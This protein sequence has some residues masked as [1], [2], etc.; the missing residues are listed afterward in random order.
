MDRL[1]FRMRASAKDEWQRIR[2]RS[3]TWGLRA[4]PLRAGSKLWQ[5]PVPVFAV[6]A[7]L[8]LYAIQMGTA[9][10]VH[11]VAVV[12]SRILLIED[13]SG[14]MDEDGIPDELKREKEILRNAL[15]PNEVQVDG[16]G[17]ISSGSDNLRT[18]LE[19]SLP[20][21]Q[22]L[23]AVYFLSDFH[24]ETKDWDCDDAAGV[25]EVRRLVRAAGVRLYLSSVGML[26]SPGLLAVAR[27][28]GGG[29]IG[30][31]TPEDSTAARTETCGTQ[32]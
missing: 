12:G 8:T 1:E 7:I 25:E 6:G 18:A 16:F 19:Q 13:V 3:E 23:D 32:L 17:A 26:P 30:A 4:V 9:P 29:L 20:N 5:V 10:A 22:G 28:S 11:G 24:P 27:E 21:N 2:P 31:R 14:S 15:V